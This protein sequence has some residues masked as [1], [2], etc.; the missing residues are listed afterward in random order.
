MFYSK[1]EINRSEWFGNLEYWT[2][3]YNPFFSKKIKLYKY[4]LNI[5][6][7]PRNI[8]NNRENSY[9]IHPYRNCFLDKTQRG[10]SYITAFMVVYIA[11][12]FTC[13]DS[14]QN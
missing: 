14:S 5:L 7:R 10:G 13:M 11:Y 2:E 1:K 8:G 4:L 9:K 3:P 6:Y 12:T